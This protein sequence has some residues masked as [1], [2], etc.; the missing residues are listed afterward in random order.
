MSTG[1]GVLLPTRTMLR[2]WMA[3]SSLVGE[4]AYFIE[5]EGAAAGC[6]EL[7]GTVGMGI[8]ERAFHV[9]EQFALEKAFGDCTHIHTYHVLPVAR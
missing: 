4:I 9:A 6:F 5:K 1:M 7:A 3:V 8:G 2:R